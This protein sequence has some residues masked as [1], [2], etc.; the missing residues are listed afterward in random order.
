MPV[1]RWLNSKQQINA[2]SIRSNALLSWKG[3]WRSSLNKWR[4]IAQVI[5]K[6]NMREQWC[7]DNLLSSV[8]HQSLVNFDMN[9]IGV[10][11]SLWMGIGW[12]A[13]RK[14]ASSG[15]RRYLPLVSQVFQPRP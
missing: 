7:V 12:H 11:D 9:P 4:C 8:V 15:L 2:W 1:E 6:D 3:R 13:S 10:E 5:D 14:D